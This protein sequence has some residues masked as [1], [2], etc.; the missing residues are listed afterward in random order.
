MPYFTN[1]VRHCAVE[2]IPFPLG[3]IFHIL[4]NT[5]YVHT[6]EQNFGIEV[7]N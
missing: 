7:R 3:M 2:F 6:A 1:R 5:I 4:G